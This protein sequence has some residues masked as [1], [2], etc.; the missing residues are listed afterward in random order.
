MV[1]MQSATLPLATAYRLREEEE[2]M[3]VRVRELIVL[4]TAA[5]KQRLIT[6]VCLKP[7]LQHSQP[8]LV[9]NNVFIFAELA[10]LRLVF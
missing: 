10:D 5:D 1:K 6:H 2:R 3:R 4:F 9:F 7:F 8:L